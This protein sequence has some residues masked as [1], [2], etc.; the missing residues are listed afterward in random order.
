[1]CIK[2]IMS[3]ENFRFATLRSVLDNHVPVSALQAI[4]QNYDSTDVEKE[5]Q[6]Q[7]LIVQICNDRKRK[8]DIIQAQIRKN[9]KTPRPTHDIVDC[10]MYHDDSTITFD[11]DW[12]ADDD[13]DERWSLV[14]TKV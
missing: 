14:A 11:D 2:E 12:S 9:Y 13:D 6:V 5:D 1:M 8:I 3:I 10:T 7:I 4:I